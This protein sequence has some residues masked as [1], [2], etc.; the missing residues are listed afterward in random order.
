MGYAKHIGRVG[1]LAVTLGVGVAVATMPGVA[2]ADPAVSSTSTDESSSTSAD[3]ADTD[4]TSTTDDATESPSAEQDEADP[5]DEV[6]DDDA[7]GDDTSTDTTDDD[8]GSE[9]EPADDEN[10]GEA[11]D[12]EDAPP[13][14]GDDSAASDAQETDDSAPRSDASDA[15]DQ[16]PSTTADTDVEPAAP[17]DPPPAQPRAEQTPMADVIPV[18]ATAFTTTSA[19]TAPATTAL[20]TP[21]PRPTLVDLVSNL[22]TAVLQP[23]LS[24]GAGSPIQLPVLFAGLAAVRDEMER[25]LFGRNTKV[26][27]QQTVSQLIDPA[28][29]NVLVIGVD[30]TNLSRILNDPANDNF[31]ELMETSTTAASSIVGHTTISNP[32]W[33]AILT[34]AWDNKTGVINNVFTPWTYDKWPTVFNQLETLNPAIETTA[35]GNWNVINAI[36]GAGSIPAD[37]NLFIPQVP[38]DT[39]WL[40]T[41]DAVGAATVAAITG[42]NASTPNFVF[43]YFVGVDENGHLYGGASPQYAEAIRNVDDNLG[44]ILDAVAAREAATGEDWTIIVVTDHGH[45]PQKGFGH[46]FQSPSETATFVMVDGPGF[47]D[48]LIN[49]EYEIVD[50]TPTVVTLFGG[51]PSPRS[52]G[53][54][55]TTLG[56]FDVDPVDLHQALRDEIAKNNYP[57]IVTNVALSA[58]TI[59]ATIP[60][61]VYELGL[62]SPVHDVLYIATNIPA[63]IVAFLTG[64]HGASIFPLL[65]P[66]PPSFPSTEDAATLVDC[67]D[68]VGSTCV[69]V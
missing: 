33:T 3:G 13:V 50:T 62:P 57:D 37:E 69:A 19:R 35:I 28:D 54:S 68:S 59:F 49:T 66:P 51:T 36:A 63:Q 43:S 23:L 42:A 61:L 29:Q 65:P 47:G 56:E 53:V 15:Q 40:A 1:A 39:N 41:D 6:T 60:Y 11:E 31:F 38:G 21:Q 52:D 64:V 24:W 4:S 25:V 16:L 22:L 32:S 58:R 48:G 14:P 44:L 67:G 45:Q 10:S 7:T 8:A 9:E 46:G 2:F 55:L 27:A 26:A 5:A 20:L 18:A 17:S 12:E 34:G 30:G